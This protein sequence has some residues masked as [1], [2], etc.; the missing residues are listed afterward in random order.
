M[1]V[2]DHKIHEIIRLENCGTWHVERAD[3]ALKSGQT[4]VAQR[5]D[6]VAFRLFRQVHELRALWG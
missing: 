6:L 1:T 3:A 5:H 4:E 2:T